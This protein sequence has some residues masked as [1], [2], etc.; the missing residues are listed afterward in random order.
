MLLLCVVIHRFL[1]EEFQSKH[2]HY[3]YYYYL[4]ADYKKNLILIFTKT[5]LPT[6]TECVTKKESVEILCRFSLVVI[7]QY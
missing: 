5:S 4:K 6:N 1:D 2:W 3:Y 7:V